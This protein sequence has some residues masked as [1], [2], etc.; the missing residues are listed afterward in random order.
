MEAGKKRSAEESRKVRDEQAKKRREAEIEDRRMLKLRHAKHVELVSMYDVHGMSH[1][2]L[3]RMIRGKEVGLYSEA[4]VQMFS[5]WFRNM[6]QAH[7]PRW[8]AFVEEKLAE[9][10]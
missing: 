4:D 3:E 7:A 10:K 1:Q 2:I 5:E 6:K 8:K 9:V